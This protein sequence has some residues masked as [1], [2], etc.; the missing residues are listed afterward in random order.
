M[1]PHDNLVP[2]ALDNAGLLLKIEVLA[3]DVRVYG[4]AFPQAHHG[5]VQHGK[6]L[7]AENLYPQ[8]FVGRLKLCRHQNG[9]IILVQ[10][11]GILQELDRVVS[12]CGYC[13]RYL[14]IALDLMVVARARVR[15]GNPP[16]LECVFLLEVHVGDIKVKAADH[17]LF[18]IPMVEDT[19][20][21]SR[22]LQV[23]L[24]L[25]RMMK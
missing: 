16:V 12:L 7:S 8:L 15:E 24:R 2:L 6:S 1:I 10:V 18:E 9:L 19:D 5:V 11:G 13:D 22:L 14:Q 4:L 21:D 23:L 17:A 3:L 20:G 25:L